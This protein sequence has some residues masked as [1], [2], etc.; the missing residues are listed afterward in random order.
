MHGGKA[1]VNQETGQTVLLP[2]APTKEILQTLRKQQI[3]INQFTEKADVFL[4]GAQLGE[5]TIP[6]LLEL[7]RRVHQAA[8]EAVKRFDAHS[9]SKIASMIKWEVIIGLIVGLFGV[10]LTRQIRKNQ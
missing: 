10:V 6:Q 8:N 3:L 7:N 1:V 4:E 5:T 2:P 9:S